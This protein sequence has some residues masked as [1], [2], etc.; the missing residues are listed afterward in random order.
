M[1]PSVTMKSYIEELNTE[2]DQTELFNIL[3]QEPDPNLR[4]TSYSF[5]AV[6][7]AFFYKD[8][9]GR[10]SGKPKTW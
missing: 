1:D 6:E 8:K 4:W 2:E 3:T 10:K 5:P 7:T 9:D